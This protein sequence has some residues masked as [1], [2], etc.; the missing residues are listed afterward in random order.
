MTIH[1]PGVLR[2]NE[3]NVNA[4]LGACRSVARHNFSA[5]FSIGIN[6]SRT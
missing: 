1:T 5:K 3:W 4:R 6:G 2:L